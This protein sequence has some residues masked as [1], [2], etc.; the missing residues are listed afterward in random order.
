MSQTYRMPKF[1]LVEMDLPQP[2]ECGYQGLDR[3]RRTTLSS[4]IHEHVRALS[5]GHDLP[6]QRC[7]VLSHARLCGDDPVVRCV[8]LAGFLIGKSQRRKKPDNDMRGGKCLLEQAML[9]GEWWHRRPMVV[10]VG[11]AVCAKDV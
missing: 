1:C 8:S 11:N 4:I 9:L 3:Q 10:Y 6:N 5:L 7:G 2:L